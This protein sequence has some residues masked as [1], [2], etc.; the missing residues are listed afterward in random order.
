VFNIRSVF[1]F[2]IIATHFGKIE[3]AE[4]AGDVSMIDFGKAAMLKN[5]VGT[6]LR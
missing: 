4:T 3:A 2:S 1:Y 5:Q 6:L